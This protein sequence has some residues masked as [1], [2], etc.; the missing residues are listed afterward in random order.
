[1]YEVPYESSNKHIPTPESDTDLLRVS[2][3]APSQVG[4]FETKQNLITDA[5]I[6]RRY[7]CDQ[8]FDKA[9]PITILSI[10]LH[11]CIDEHLASKQIIKTV[12]NVFFVIWS[13]LKQVNC[14]SPH[15]V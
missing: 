9:P 5:K 8:T 10:R 6:L 2:K 4:S 3:C 13:V 14:V 1:M 7:F 11:M 15:W 12:Q